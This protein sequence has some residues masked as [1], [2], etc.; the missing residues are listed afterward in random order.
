MEF[1]SIRMDVIVQKNVIL[2]IVGAKKWEVFAHL[3]V[4][5]QNVKTKK[6]I[7]VRTKFSLFINPAPVKK[8]KL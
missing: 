1:K 2:I 6:F 5:V 8:T 3:F 7:L 4:D